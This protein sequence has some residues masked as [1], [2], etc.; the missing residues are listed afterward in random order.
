LLDKSS[1]ENIENSSRSH[2]RPGASEAD[3]LANEVASRSLVLMVLTCL[4]SPAAGLL[5][6]RE[7][8]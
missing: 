3:T 2:P 1:G 7:K 6:G 8:Q 4:L 5:L